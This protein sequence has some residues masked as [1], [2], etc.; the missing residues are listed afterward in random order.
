VQGELLVASA[1]DKSPRAIREGALGRPFV[2]DD[3]DRDPMVRLRKP[4]GVKPSRQS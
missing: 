1:P 4:A 2:H 3:H